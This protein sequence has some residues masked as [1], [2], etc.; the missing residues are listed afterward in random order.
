MNEASSLTNPATPESQLPAVIAAWRRA[1]PWAIAVAA[2]LVASVLLLNRPES[3]PR[4]TVRLQATPGGDLALTVDPF[5]TDIA[6]SQDGRRIAYMTGTTQF[7]LHVRELDREDAVPLGGVA[8]VRGPFF[9]PDGHWIRTS[10]T[11]T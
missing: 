5:A 1:L 8:N 9:S 4:R 6:I 10:R 2:T 11:P 3:S 7:Q